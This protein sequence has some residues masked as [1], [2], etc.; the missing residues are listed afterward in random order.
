MLD[1]FRE[2]SP[3]ALAAISEELRVRQASKLILAFANGSQF[4]HL[5]FQHGPKRGVFILPADPA[6]VT[7]D[8]VIA[9]NPAGMIGTGGPASIHSER[10][11]FDRRIFD[12]D[13]PFLGMCLSGQ[14][15]AD[16]FGGTVAR[17]RAQYSVHDMYLTAAGKRSPLFADCPDVMPILQSHGDEITNAGQFEVL[18]TCDGVIAALGFGKR[19]AV[20]GHLE[21]D[22]TTQGGAIFNNFFNICGIIERFPAEDVLARKIEELRRL[23]L[24]G[25]RI[26]LLLSG[27]L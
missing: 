17:G 13:I 1:T 12:L 10:P 4:D 18:A 27:G 3:E 19:F 24:T 7:V 2:A 16:Y 9:L 26:L 8:D 11:P 23:R 22:E 5:L 6:S 20:Q 21:C 15:I 25:V 14:D